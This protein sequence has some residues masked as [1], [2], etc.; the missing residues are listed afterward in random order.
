[1]TNKLSKILSKNIAISLFGSLVTSCATAK[2]TNLPMT[3]SDFTKPKVTAFQKFGFDY[4][5]MPEGVQNV[6]GIEPTEFNV[7]LFVGNNDDCKVI[8]INS[9]DGKKDKQSKTSV[10]KA[11][12]SAQD[13]LLKVIC[14]G[15][16]SNID[17][18]IIAKA[19]DIEYTH[20]G[21]LSYFAESSK[22]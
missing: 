8:Y 5:A 21:N 4:E 18:K 16:E 19:N 13:T 6:D 7:H 2:F 17:Y 3:N 10:F 1:M 15:E 20:I 12:L 14:A 22:I 11:Y 9:K